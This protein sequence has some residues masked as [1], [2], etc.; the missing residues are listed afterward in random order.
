MVLV[1]RIDVVL[2]PWVVVV[3]TRPVGADDASRSALV[4]C[5]PQR[6][7][8]IRFRTRDSLRERNHWDLDKS[9]CGRCYGVLVRTFRVNRV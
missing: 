1:L 3:P 7:S 4:Y 5:R 9:F 6:R 2:V 8:A